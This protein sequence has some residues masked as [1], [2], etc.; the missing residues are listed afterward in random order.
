[1]ASV[2]ENVV[3]DLDG[4]L[5]D[6]APGIERC[7]RHA[8]AEVAP[9]D[10]GAAVPCALIGP[11]VRVMVASMLPGADDALVDAAVLA[12]RRCYDAGG[13]RETVP[14]DGAGELLA[15]LHGAGRRIYVVTNKPSVPT[16]QILAEFEWSGL[17]G[18]VVCRDSVTP[19]FPDKSAALRHLIETQSLE[20]SRTIFVGDT[21]DDAVAA[22]ANELPFVFASYGYGA[23]GAGER[24]WATI[25]QPRALLPVVGAPPS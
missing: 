3:F 17:I 2:I 23:P 25:S 12:F 20:Q 19:W 18:A 6:S 13:W 21:A 11:P 7:L 8:V 14:Y 1:M 5:V 15:T 24:A 22:Q 10:P 16:G 4:T 9:D